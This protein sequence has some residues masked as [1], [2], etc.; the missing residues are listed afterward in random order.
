LRICLSEVPA[1]FQFPAE[2]R[3]SRPPPHLS[4]VRQQEITKRVGNL[5]DWEILKKSFEPMK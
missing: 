2:A 1:D 3:E 4:E 5:K